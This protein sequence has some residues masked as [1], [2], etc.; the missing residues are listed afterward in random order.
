[1]FLD[2]W[3]NNFTALDSS[4]STAGPWQEDGIFVQSPILA[5]L[6]TWT[7]ANP[8]LISKRA[9]NLCKSIWSKANFSDQPLL[10]NPSIIYTWFQPLDVFWSQKLSIVCSYIC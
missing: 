2:G 6:A 4:R 8:F 7:F 9:D 3:G 1:M 10:D 5:F